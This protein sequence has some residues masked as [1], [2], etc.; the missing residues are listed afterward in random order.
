MQITNKKN[1]EKQ[2][3]ISYG[4]HTATSKNVNHLQFYHTCTQFILFYFFY[5]KENRQFKYMMKR[6][7]TCWKCAA[8]ALRRNRL[9][10]SILYKHWTHK[11]TPTKTSQFNK[12][13]A[14]Y[15]Q[16]QGEPAKT[17][18][19]TQ[20]EKKQTEGALRG[21]YLRR[22]R[23]MCSFSGS[24]PVS[25]VSL[26]VREQHMLTVCENMPLPCAWEQEWI[27][28][29]VL[30]VDYLQSTEFCSLAA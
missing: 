19:D 2:N 28:R 29:A 30:S 25:V 27:L 12:M 5:S 22:N 9:A 14:C 24:L 13:I 1:K 21:V 3:I 6:T 26:S 18:K 23:W 16:R 11:N 20:R 15:R 10:I 8:K 4:T 17:K 7:R